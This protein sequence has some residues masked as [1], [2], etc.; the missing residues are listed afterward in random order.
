MVDNFDVACINR[1]YGWYL[2]GGR[3]EAADQHLKESTIPTSFSASFINMTEF[4]ADHPPR[5]AHS[6]KWSEEYQV[7][8]LRRYLDIAARNHMAGMQV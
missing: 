8:I 1:Y 6:L 7:E 4:G 5:D 3:P 2:P